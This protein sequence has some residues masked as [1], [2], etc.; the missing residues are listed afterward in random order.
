[1][2]CYQQQQP[3]QPVFHHQPNILQVRI[4]KYEVLDYCCVNH[5]AVIPGCDYVVIDGD[6]GMDIGLVESVL[7]PAMW[8]GTEQQLKKLKKAYY[9]DNS[10]GDKMRLREIENQRALEVIRERVKECKLQNDMVVEDVHFQLD[11]NKMTIFYCRKHPNRKVSRDH[12]HSVD[13]R[14]LQRILF[15]DFRCRLWLQDL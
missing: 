2:V 14:G 9:V 5:F 12:E 6:R 15:R 11:Y 4:N 3:L 1:L 13:F 8:G 7:T 10:C